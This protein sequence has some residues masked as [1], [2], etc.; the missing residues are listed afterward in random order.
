M[1]RKYLRHVELLVCFNALFLTSLR[2]PKKLLRKSKDIIET[3]TN[4]VLEQKQ[5]VSSGF[6][7]L[8]W[9]IHLLSKY[10]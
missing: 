2:W 9:L 4:M 5:Y 10:T 7:F 6:I 8:A 1:C 3:P